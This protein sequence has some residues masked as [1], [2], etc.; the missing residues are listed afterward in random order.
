MQ[1]APAGVVA[2][3]VPGTRTRPAG[4]VHEIVCIVRFRRVLTVLTLAVLALST[5]TAC[6]TKI[7]QAAEV[8]SATLSDSALAGLVEPG[9][10]PY[11]DQSGQ[12]VPKLNALTT[13]VRNELIKAAI[14][15]RGGAAS[16][17]E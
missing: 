1:V 6:R 13:W 5:L 10:A 16:T 17:D 14:A 8:G 15:S 3:T 7:G 11:T 9:S 2:G 4:L 12:V